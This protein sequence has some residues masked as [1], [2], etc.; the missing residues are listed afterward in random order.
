MSMAEI[1]EKFPDAEVFELTNLIPA[2]EVGKGPW[3][4]YIF[5]WDGLHSG[6]QWFTAG[7]IKYPDEEISSARAKEKAETAVAK[8]LEVRICDGMDHL[9]FHSRKGKVV[10]GETFWNEAKPNPVAV[11]VADRLLGKKTK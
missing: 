3:K 1:L 8:G 4:L 11:A 7:K 2:E 5:G 6:G 9:V 10:L